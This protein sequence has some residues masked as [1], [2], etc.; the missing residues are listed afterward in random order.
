MWSPDSTE[1]ANS[2]D[3]KI[4]R[5]V[6]VAVLFAASAL[7]ALGADA[8]V[9]KAGAQEK[10]PI[11]VKLDRII[12]KE[13][14]E[15]T[16]DAEVARGGI[17]GKIVGGQKANPQDWRFF[18][19][20]TNARLSDYGSLTGPF[21]GSV[22]IADG[23]VATAAHCVVEE[24]GINTV[25]GMPDLSIKSGTAHWSSNIFI[26]PRFDE[27]T[28]AWDIALIKV[29]KSVDLTGIP[30]AGSLPEAD[31]PAKVAGFG[32]Q[33]ENDKMG[34]RVLKDVNLRLVSDSACSDAYPLWF[35][36]RSMLCASAPAKDA[37]QGD[38]GGP[39][40]SQG[41]LL[42]L[43]SWGLGCAR[44]GMPGVYA[45]I[46]ALVPW[47]ESVMESGGDRFVMR[48]IYK[49]DDRTGKY[50]LGAF[51]Q[52]VKAAAV[53]FRHRVCVG[54]RCV[55]GGTWV[56]S[57]KLGSYMM[58][59]RLRRAKKRCTTAT[60]RATTDGGAVTKTSKVCLPR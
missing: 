54:S 16:G 60:I 32:R 41:K 38:S 50:I 14:I 22:V 18:G 12:S 7:L 55:K 31:S 26:H 8:M 2:V 6:A 48:G 3:Q 29:P 39:L 35:D 56:R 4:R 20:L 43:V 24:D 57:A 52:P 21:C 30:L 19:S 46:P 44:P 51:S 45:R 34:S 1:I 11:A 49:G 15:A 27:E 13:K 5:F 37:C 25:T 59:D 58:N 10:S 17:S 28:L 42:G 53:K 33:Y 47:I 36:S 40:V 23:W 9:A